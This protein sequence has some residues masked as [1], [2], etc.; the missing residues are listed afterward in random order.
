ML[1]T[2]VLFLLVRGCESDDSTLPPTCCF[3]ATDSPC[4]TLSVDECEYHKFAR[5][6]IANDTW[7]VPRCTD[8]C[9]KP[10]CD[11]CCAT[12]TCIN[13]DWS[14]GFCECTSST[15]TLSGCCGQNEHCSF[16]NAIPL[17]NKSLFQA[18][19]TCCPLNRGGPKCDECARG[20]F[21]PDCDKECPTAFGRVCNGFGTCADG[22]T[23]DGTCTCEPG[24]LPPDCIQAEPS[25]YNC[26][27]FQGEI[28]AGH[29][30]CTSML[31]PKVWNT[32]ILWRLLVVAGFEQCF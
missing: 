21:G 7:G 17:A 3:S 25:M 31:P 10:H 22:M 2:C 9:G 19:G 32:Y 29:G 12:Q 13:Y 18:N 14:C 30:V 8:S 15:S 27:S 6:Y 24:H 20:M 28:C 11:P 4:A 26:S 5:C 1:V 23:G 16:F